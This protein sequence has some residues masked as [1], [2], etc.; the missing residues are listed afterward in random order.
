MPSLFAKGVVDF[1]QKKIAEAKLLD[2]EKMIYVLDL[3][4][5]GL[6]AGVPIKYNYFLEVM[7]DSED[8]VVKESIKT[9]GKIIAS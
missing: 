2:T 1:N 8:P 5:N 6:K 4:I 3:I 7:R 9:L